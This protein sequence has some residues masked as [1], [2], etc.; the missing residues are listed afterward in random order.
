[1]KI[2][3]TLIC[4]IW[5]SSCSELEPKPSN[6]KYQVEPP[7]VEIL[8]DWGYINSNNI[9]RVRYIKIDGIICVQYNGMHDGSVTPIRNVM[10][11]Q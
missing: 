6:S 11:F 3:L 7:V 4:L 8:S 2:I 5:V 1:M 9:D 10:K